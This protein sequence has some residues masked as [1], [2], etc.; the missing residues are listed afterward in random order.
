MKY[1]YLTIRSMI[2][3]FLTLFLCQYSIS[4]HAH[5]SHAHPLEK[6]E[7]IDKANKVI[8][9]AIDQKK[10]EPSWKDAKMVEAKVLEEKGGQWL[11]HY[12]NPSVNTENKNLF[13]F[14]SLDGKYTAMNH[15]G[16]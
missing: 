9:M 16:K 6:Q 4:A 7:I 1:G 8:G 5:E 14:F 2:F 15:T 11:V 12:N 13:I 10:L 3:S